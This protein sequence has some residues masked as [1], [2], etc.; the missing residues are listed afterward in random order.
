MGLHI[1]PER[2]ASL[3][4]RAFQAW[5]VLDAATVIEWLGNVVVRGVTTVALHGGT[6]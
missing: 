4:E 3:L 2:L 5:G 1:C 6:A